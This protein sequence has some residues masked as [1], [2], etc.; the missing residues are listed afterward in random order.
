M[1]PSSPSGGRASPNRATRTRWRA[2]RAAI[3]AVSAIWLFAW[4][5]FSRSARISASMHS[6]TLLGAKGIRPLPFF[7]L[8]MIHLLIVVLDSG[9][10]R[11]DELLYGHGAPC[12]YVHI[13]A[14][15]ST[16]TFGSPI[17]AARFMARAR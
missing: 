17:S 4:L 2:H 15:T 12:P 10:R 9:F 1:G 11:N 5:F 16:L 13:A 14:T 3:C 8:S 6:L 7:Y